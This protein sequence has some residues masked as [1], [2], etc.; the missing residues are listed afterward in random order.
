MFRSQTDEAIKDQVA[1]D[2]NVIC[3]NAYQY[4]I[5]ALMLGGG[6]GSFVNYQIPGRLTTNA[7]INGAYAI[8][9]TPTT[10]SISFTVTA[11]AIA[12]GMS[13]TVDSTA[14]IIVTG[15]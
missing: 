6:S 1:N 3:V 5:K 7:N 10:G 14:K 9:G 4:R 11:P 13:A 8:N 15:R 12:I 2:L